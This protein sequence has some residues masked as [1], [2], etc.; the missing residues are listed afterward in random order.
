M[1][2]NLL[3]LMLASVLV[4]A[5]CD[6]VSRI[7]SDIKST[8]TSKIS[9]ITSK[10]HKSSSHGLKTESFDLSG[11]TAHASLDIKVELPKTNQGIA[12]DQ[13]RSRLIDIM[14]NELAIEY[15]GDM[16]KRI[17][18]AYTGDRND[19]KALMDY[20]R[21][22]KKEAVAKD[23]QESFNRYGDENWSLD[24]SWS[25]ER[26]CE[27]DGFIVF[28]SHGY[29]HASDMMHAAA[30]GQGPFTF[31]KKDGHQVT[32]FLKRDSQY[33]IQ[34]ILR[35]GLAEYFSVSPEDVR[36]EL[37]LEEGFIP[38]PKETPQPTEDGLSF[39][40]QQY[41][42]SYGAAGEPVFT[43]PFEEILPFCTAEAVKLFLGN[44]KDVTGEL[45]DRV[46]ELCHYIPD[47][48]MS[49]NTATYMTPD[50]YRALTEAWAAPDGAYGEIGESEWLFYFV[51]AQDGSPVFTVKS[52]LQ[53]DPSNAIAFVDNNTT[54]G[55]GFPLQYFK[56]HFIKL[57]KVDGKWLMDDFDGVKLQCHDYVQEMRR[58]Y[59]SGEILQYLLSDEYSR[60]YVPDFM[61]SVEAFYKEY[62]NGDNPSAS[63]PKDYTYSGSLY[64]DS[65]SYGIEMRFTESVAGI[66]G[67]YRYLSMSADK[68]LPI[69][70]SRSSDGKLHIYTEKGNE[71]FILQPSN[72]GT[73]LS[74]EW[75]MYNDASELH[76]DP[77]H[78]RW[79][80]HLQV[81]LQQK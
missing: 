38:L 3:F 61:E 25:L 66:K 72:G 41:E 73:S 52:V 70:G 81:R 15:S 58:Q 14:D 49:I 64:N 24:Y 6:R 71:L 67:R 17:F 13:I 23:S 55:E 40:Y 77:G 65:N 33:E 18:P 54:F 10:S 43:V 34:S 46:Q 11:E 51:S 68:F 4:F 12:A 28:N 69:Y 8:I 27:T 79:K 22:K 19:S 20:Y 35:K 39:H 56:E 62:G 26:T 57:T 16:R 59:E 29:I 74:G 5:S 50:L 80:K 53:T 63:A 60:E 76:Y 78:Y 75:Y 2:K 7:A 37:N 9:R 30:I 31:D 44:Y 32:A 48:G 45:S 47:H 42:I 21:E 1:K 36:N